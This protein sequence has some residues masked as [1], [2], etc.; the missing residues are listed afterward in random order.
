R[1]RGPP[2]PAGRGGPGQRP[3]AAGGR[4]RGAPGDR[5][6]RIADDTVAALGRRLAAGEVSS[7][8]VTEGCLRRI[9]A[10]SS[11][12][13]WLHVDAEGAL[14]AAD[15]ADARRARGQARGPL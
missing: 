3:R 8:E 1:G 12:G 4:L 10:T 14:A 6:S 2:R 9:E 11:L 5:V 13:A 15:A 7:R